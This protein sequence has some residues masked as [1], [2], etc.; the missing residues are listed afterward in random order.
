M[1]MVFRAVQP[2]VLG[3][4]SLLMATMLLVEYPSNIFMY[5]LVAGFGAFGVSAFFRDAESQAIWDLYFLLEPERLGCDLVVV[6]FRLPAIGEDS[7]AYRGILD[8]YSVDED[9]RLDSLVLSGA[10]FA[11]GAPSEDIR[12]WQATDGETTVIQVGRVGAIEI[13][14]EYLFF[15]EI[16]NAELS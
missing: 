11:Q 8:S 12:D 13:E 5:L 9:G 16:S 15:K 7:R 2:P 4:A 14:V 6:L 1:N 10:Y 3:L